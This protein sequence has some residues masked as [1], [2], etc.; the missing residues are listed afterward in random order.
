MPK[1]ESLGVLAAL[2]DAFQFLIDL[3][4]FRTHLGVAGLLRPA[5]RGSAIDAAAAGAACPIAREPCRS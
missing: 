3:S 1:H 4:I 5:S 2:A